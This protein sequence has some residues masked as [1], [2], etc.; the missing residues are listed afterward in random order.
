MS[1]DD[2]SRDLASLRIQ[3]EQKAPP[4]GGG[5]GWIWI[6]VACLLVAGGGAALYRKQKDRLFAPE[7]QLGQVSLLSP[8][9]A[10]VTL[11]ATGYVVS[12]RKATL[13]ARTQGR[14]ARLFVD[15]GDKVKQGQLIAEI[16][17]ADVSSARAIVEEARSQLVDAQ[18]KAKRET[19]LLAR[20][21]GTQAATDDANARL[22]TAKASLSS[23]EAN[24]DAIQS[25]I[26]SAQVSLDYTQVR[27]PFDATVLRKLTEVGEMMSPNGTGIVSI[28]SLADLQVE[29][30]V[31]ETQLSKVM[32]SAPPKPNTTPLADRAAG[33]PAEIVLDAFPDRRFRGVVADVRP[34]VDRAKATVTVKVRFVDPTEGVLPDMSAKVSF[35]SK[36]IDE[37]ALGQAPKR[38]IPS[39]ALVERD[40]RRVVLTVEKETVKAVPVVVK[41]PAASGLLE[42]SDGPSPGVQVVRAPA[43]ELRDGSRVKTGS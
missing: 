32:L 39:D 20:G 22:Q 37:A 36:P 25:H 4:S 24:V 17:R 23:A 5:R 28:A 19:D 21:A 29:A 38:V 40:G 31:S 2:L 3:R 8:S 13:A 34:T 6:L 1:T 27:A 7:V 16:D 11:V 30:D 18:I 26:R 15:E 35:L 43:A 33:A 9:Q 10:D 42:I 41:G 12:R 14:L